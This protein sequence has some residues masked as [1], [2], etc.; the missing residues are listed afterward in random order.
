MALPS[1][2]LEGGAAGQGRKEQVCGQEG[3]P[4]PPYIGEGVAGQ[5]WVIA[6]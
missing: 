4:T 6:P 2:W 3:A 1:G 5:G